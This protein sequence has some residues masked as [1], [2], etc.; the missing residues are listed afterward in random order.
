MTQ[1]EF[2][3]S[4]FHEVVA[5]IIDFFKEMEYIDLSQLPSP[6]GL[7][8]VRGF[9]RS[10]NVWLIDRQPVVPLAEPWNNS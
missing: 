8:L 6:K 3:L 4:K 5:D 10:P 9:A 1:D 7:R 2:P